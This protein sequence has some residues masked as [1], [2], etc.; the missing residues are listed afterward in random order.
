MKVIK[1]DGRVVDYDKTK[2]KIAVEKANTEVGKKEKA[3]KEDIKTITEYIEELGKKRILVEDIQDIIEAKL[4]ELGKYELAKKYIVYRYT[5]ALVRK[6]NTTDES[7][8]GLIRR[9]NKDVMEE[10]SNKNAIIASTQRDLI[11][12]EVSKD[13]S[14]RIL[15]PEKIINA[16]ED[17][18]LHFHDADYFIQPIFNCCL[19]NIGDMLD[20]GTVMNGKMIDSPKSFQVACIVTSQIIATVASNQYGGQSIDM[21]HLGK[22]LRKSKE[23]FEK[24]IIEELGEDFDK[25]VVDKL[26]TKRLKM[27]LSAG[28]QTIQYQINTLM[29]TNGQAPFV[30]LFLHIDPNDEYIEE[31]AMII[32][33]VL[34][35]RLQG[36]KN[37]AGVYVTPAFPK[38]VYVLDECNNLTGGKYDYLTK[39]AV[40]CSAKRMYPDYI[41]A[42]KMRENY[43]GNVFSPMGCRSFLIP[44]KDENG[45]YKFEGRFNQGVVSINLPQVAIV[46]EGD[47]EKFWKLLD[48]RLELCKE[49]LMCRHYALVGTSADISPIHWRYGAIA[50]LEQGEKI[51][52]LLYGGYST[53]SL[54][55]IGI[56]EMTKLMKGVP[57]TAPEGHDFAIKVMQY[58]KDKT[59]KWRKET[60]I[61]FSLYGTPAESLCY[62]FARIDKERFGTIEDVTDKGYYTNSYH[63][64]VREKIDAFEKLKFESEFQQLSGGGAISYV[65]IPNMKNNIPALEA[66]IKYIYENIQYAEV[67]TKSDYCHVCGFDGEI[68]IN[69]D[70]E[71]ECPNCGNKD[72]SKL[73]V[74]R[75]TCGYLGENF[76]NVGKTKE[77]KARVLHL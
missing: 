52:K 13:L 39:L 21:I 63:V 34:R 37:S 19:I 8:L 1:R 17:G 67:N 62:R 26:V 73:T 66:L 43:E 31:N 15:L 22:Y 46:A 36:I 20:N 18:I 50:R 4:M 44:W 53:I 41:S 2:I 77:I 32:E 25:K 76:W 56:Y 58:L 75:R 6:S 61:G 60:N 38:L 51:D 9:S 57:H 3:S 59:L 29:T 47:E 7:I 35:Q 14:K 45:N 54:G 24:E 74:V 42:K 28:V 71:W 65:E 70:L 64:D 10:N 68:L 69:K 48:E 16:W 72:H 11:A 30:T 27:E 40:E 23:K 5:R 49:A 33:E 55:Y 12:G